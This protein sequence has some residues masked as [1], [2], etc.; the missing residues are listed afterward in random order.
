LR[1][2]VQRQRENIPA[3][4]NNILRLSQDSNGSLTGRDLVN[5]VLLCYVADVGDGDI[6]ELVTA[7][8]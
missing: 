2:G 1:L 7:P 4:I 5:Q 6:E 3:V 8:V